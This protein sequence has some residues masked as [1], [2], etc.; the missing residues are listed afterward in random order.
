MELRLDSYTI[1]MFSWIFSSLQCSVPSKLRQPCRN[2]CT[3]EL[4]VRRLQESWL[5]VYSCGSWTRYLAH[6][7][8]MAKYTVMKLAFLV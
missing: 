8:T 7:W 1:A 2:V 6:P 3:S 4:S 5:P